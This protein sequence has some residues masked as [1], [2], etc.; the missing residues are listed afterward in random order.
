MAGI[1]DTLISSALTLTFACNPR[2]LFELL[3]VLLL[4]KLLELLLWASS[5]WS[6]SNVELYVLNSVYLGENTVALLLE[7][8]VAEL[9]EEFKL[10]NFG[11]GAVGVV[12]VVTVLLCKLVKLVFKLLLLF[13]F[14]TDDDID[15]MDVGVVIIFGSSTVFG[16][17]KSNESRDLYNG[18]KEKHKT[19]FDDERNDK[20]I[21]KL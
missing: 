5:A 4:F 3:V 14:V 7:E 11:C 18:K 10:F 21:E 20:Q 6:P 8:Q 16:E 2:L 19:W 17:F 15:L 13:N 1:D 12:G 9:A